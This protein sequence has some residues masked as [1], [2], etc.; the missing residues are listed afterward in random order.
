MSVVS[1]FGRMKCRNKL[2]SPPSSITIVTQII[3]FESI[4]YSDDYQGDEAA[5]L[6]SDNL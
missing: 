6:R 3:T 2:H 4:H 1:H 5:M